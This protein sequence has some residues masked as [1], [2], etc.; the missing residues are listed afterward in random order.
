AFE[1]PIPPRRLNRSIPP[2]L[3]TIVLKA[4]EKNPAERYGTARELAEDLQLFLDDKPI[5]AKRS[6]LLQIARKWARRHP[7]VV[8]A[9]VTSSVLFLLALVI[10]LAISNAR[11]AEAQKQLEV[12][13]HQQVLA[14]VQH[15]REVGNLG[16]AEELL[17]NPRFQDLHG[18]E[19]HYLK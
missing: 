3:E 8:W 13:L 12:S 14:R 11:I 5:R 18:W 7:A 4:L 10:V 19:W 17:D 1:E 16:L 6:S 9:A 15:E 2:E